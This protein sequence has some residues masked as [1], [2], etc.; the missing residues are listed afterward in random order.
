[1]WN[2]LDKMGFDVSQFIDEDY[3]NISF[4]VCYKGTPL[5]EITGEGR[6]KI[7]ECLKE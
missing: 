3:G 7:F 5:F 6:K 1:M 2:V 4:W